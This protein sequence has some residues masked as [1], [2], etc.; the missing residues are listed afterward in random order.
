MHFS[1][2]LL[3]IWPVHKLRKWIIAHNHVV[4]VGQLP[5]Q[6]K[7]NIFSTIRAFFRVKV[8][9][10]SKKKI[11]ACRSHLGRPLVTLMDESASDALSPLADRRTCTHIS[12]HGAVLPAVS[13]RVQL[14]PL[15][16][17]G[18]EAWGLP[19]RPAP[20]PARF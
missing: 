1:K 7:D 11:W 17:W 4:I 5:F 13:L 18:G 19:Q 9:Q 20:G 14:S 6:P 12:A 10:S 15:D 16:W 3:N 2:V 8:L